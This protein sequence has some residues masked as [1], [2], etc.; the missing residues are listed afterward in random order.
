MAL[1][2]LQSLDNGGKQSAAMLATFDDL[3]WLDIQVQGPG[4][5]RISDSNLE[6]QAGQS[7]GGVLPGRMIDQTTPFSG[8]WRGQLW[9]VANQS[10]GVW[11]NLHAFQPA[12]AAPGSSQSDPSM[13][14]SPEEQYA[15]LTHEDEKLQSVPL[16]HQQTISFSRGWTGPSGRI[17][18]FVRGLGLALALAWFI[19]PLRGALVV[20]TTDSIIQQHSL[21]FDI[22]RNVSWG[23]SGASGSNNNYIFTPFNPNS[24]VCIQLFNQDPVNTHTFNVNAASTF[25]PT[26]QAFAGNTAK[27]ITSVQVATLSGVVS[28]NGIAVGLPANLSSVFYFNARAAANVV[29]TLVTAGGDP[30]VGTVTI[31]GSFTDMSTCFSTV[32]GINGNLL[33]S[34][35]FFNALGSLV[36]SQESNTAFGTDSNGKGAEGIF[37][38]PEL[39][40]SA[41]VLAQQPVNTSN[42]NGPWLSEKGARWSVTSQPTAGTQASA[43][44][45]AGAAGVRHIADCASFSAASSAAVTATAVI[46]QLLDGATIIWQHVVAFPTAGAGGIQEVQPFTI[47]GLALVGSTATSMTMQFAVGVTGA[48]EVVDLSG[49][50]VR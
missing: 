14:M 6:L 12:S 37:V 32:N 50:D 27:W 35:N 20:A 41:A 31:V 48:F 40:A 3:S 45:A 19:A 18:R 21:Y 42:F 38:S 23:V 4:Q 49:Y 13:L 30:V 1:K 47:C 44:K 22:A 28:A 46:V 5:I 8:W 39:A 17:A 26:V 43:V 11:F 24:G 15:I 16:E 10:T 9:G 25:D 36:S 34:I 29:F 2:V 7:S 33:Q